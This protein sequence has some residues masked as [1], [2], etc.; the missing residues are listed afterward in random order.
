[1]KRI[2][3]EINICDII[4]RIQS[5]TFYI[6]EAQRETGI[7]IRLAAKMQASDDDKTQLSDH[8]DIACNELVKIISK[9]FSSCILK[10]KT[11]TEKE[12]NTNETAIYSFEIPANYPVELI[13][14]LKTTM[15]NYIVTRSVQ[16]WFM[17]CK[18]DEAAIIAN[19]TLNAVNNLNEIMGIRRRPQ[20]EQRKDNN[21]IDI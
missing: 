11:E 21:R 3:T 5:H 14:E 15:I 17:Q 6:G 12:E 13:S 1:M 2:R 9:R 20:K 4:L 19:E 18:P 8:I 16:L 10:K 7:P